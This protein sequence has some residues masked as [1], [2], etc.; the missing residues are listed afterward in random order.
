VDG[1]RPTM[2]DRARITAQ[3]FLCNAIL[4]ALHHAGNKQLFPAGVDA[5]LADD[6]A[7]NMINDF[8]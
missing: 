3:R 5:C 6:C 2:R 7:G 1:E 8:S 4:R